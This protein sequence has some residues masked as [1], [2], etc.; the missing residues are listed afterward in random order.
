MLAIFGVG[1]FTLNVKPPT[2]AANIAFVSSTTA[3]VS[4]AA[5]SI[6]INK[7]AGVVAGDVMVA[8][9]LAL[10]GTANTVSITEPTGWVIAWYK[11][12]RQQVLYGR[13]LQNSYR[14][15][16]AKLYFFFLSELYG[17][18]RYSRFYRGRYG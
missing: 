5:A 1:I 10:P 17:S 8:Q 15:R 9:I 2:V 12:N 7:P 3:L 18:R 4:T 13:I 11:S 16:R 14:F 6:V